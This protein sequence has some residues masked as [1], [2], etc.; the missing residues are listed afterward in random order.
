MSHET[1]Q[2]FS[3]EELAGPEPAFS[4]PPSAFVMFD[5]CFLLCF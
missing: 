4:F 3:K 1:L 5:F 2:G